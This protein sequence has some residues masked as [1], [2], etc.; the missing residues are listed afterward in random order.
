M[1][2]PE[3]RNRTLKSRYY[4]KTLATELIIL[5]S[6]MDLERVVE[7][8]TMFSEE[9]PKQIRRRIQRLVTIGPD[10]RALN[11]FYNHQLDIYG[12]KSE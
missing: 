12:P 1:L 11:E 2:D 10:Q 6:N 8:Y 7:H 3:Y 4:N 9:D 5:T